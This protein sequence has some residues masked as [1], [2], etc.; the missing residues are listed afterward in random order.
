MFLLLSF[1]LVHELGTQ[2]Q[3]GTWSSMYTL[4]QS[5]A[6]PSVMIVRQRKLSALGKLTKLTPQWRV[7][8]SA[9]WQN[10]QIKFCY[11][12]DS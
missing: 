1:W 7:S 11:V 4:Q 5:V 10:E 9:V 6:G 12:E 3:A 2:N 8:E